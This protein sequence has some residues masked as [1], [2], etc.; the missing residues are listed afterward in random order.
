MYAIIIFFILHWYLSLFSQT[1][2]LHRYSAHGLFSMNKFWERFFYLFN[3]LSQGSSYL[4]P[5]AYAILHRMHHEYSDTEMDPHSPHH[6]ENLFTMMW[7][8]KKIY[9][10]YANYKTAPEAKYE[11]NLPVWLSLDNIADNWMSRV[12]WGT[13]YTLFYIYFVP[14]GMWYLYL[15]LPVHYLMGPVHGAIVNWCGHKYGYANFDNHDQSK[16][17]LPIDVLLGGELFQNNHHKYSARLNFASKWFE[18]DPSF[19]VIKFLDFV[20]IIKIKNMASVS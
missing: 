14:A 5:R 2:F 16:N 13:A 3:Y 11:K 4:N 6:T 19:T 9:Q 15:L 18:I 20:K 1:F 8:T 10:G 7:K 17:S 12:A